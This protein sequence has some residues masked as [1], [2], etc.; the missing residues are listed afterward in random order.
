MDCVNV[1]TSKLPRGWLQLRPA[2]PLRTQSVTQ[3][4]ATPS[5]TFPS[6]SHLLLWP[7]SICPC[8]SGRPAPGLTSTRRRRF[9]LVL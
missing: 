4:P 1:L 3:N 9:Q 8:L 7:A 6:P 5:I 2:N